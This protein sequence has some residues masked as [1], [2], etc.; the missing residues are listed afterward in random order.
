MKYIIYKRTYCGVE[1]EIPIIFPN[2]LVHLD[3][4]KA[5]KDVVGSS[6]IIAAGEFSSLNISAENFNGA[7]QTIG[8]KSRGDRD[9]K[10]IQTFDYMSGLS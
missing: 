7:S 1:Q 3:V 9:G 8:I 2:Q 6:K 5:L 4:A 10:L